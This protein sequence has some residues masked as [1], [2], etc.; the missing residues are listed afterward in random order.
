LGGKDI[1]KIFISYSRHDVEWAEKMKDSLHNHEVFFDRASLRAGDSC[2]TQILDSLTQCD[3]LVVLWSKHAKESP[4]VSREVGHFD[5]KRFRGGK[6]VPGNLLLH[7]LLDET[8]SAYAS[9]QAV[10][11]IRDAGAYQF[12]ASRVSPQVWDAALDQIARALQDPALPVSLAVLTLTRPY[13]TREGMTT[14]AETTRCVDFDFV[15]PGGRSLHDL[16]NSM[17]MSAGQLAEFYGTQ[18]DQWRPFGGQQSIGEILRDLK[19]QLNAAPKATPIRWV[20]VDDELL[21]DDSIK[22]GNAANQL[23]SGLSLVVFDPVALY[24]HWI[25]SYIPYLEGCL[26]NPHAI[27]AVLPIFPTPAEPRQ[28]HTRMIRQVFVRLVDQFYEELPLIEHAQCSI[29]AA[30]D[31]DIRRMVRGT[32]R[33]FASNPRQGATSAF[34]GM[35][36]R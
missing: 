22:I 34:L 17:N 28:T 6:P 29:F 11:S 10:T 19:Q 16:M 27:I 30:D 4:W 21:S 5:G 15:P 25:R 36:R 33:D 13:I 32:L 1:V 8:G 18:R 24:S 14:A 2:E 12:P 26:N 7:V 23:A 35:G 3:H 20:A 31:A 9:D